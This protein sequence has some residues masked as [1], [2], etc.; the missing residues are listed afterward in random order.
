MTSLL[1]TETPA[2]EK[3]EEIESSEKYIYHFDNPLLKES[4]YI[5]IFGNRIE[6]LFPE[7]T[8]KSQFC[9]PIK[10][11]YINKQLVFHTNWLPI[12]TS[13]DFLK[14]QDI[15][16]R[17]YC[18]YTTVIHWNVWPST[19]ASPKY[20]NESSTL[21]NN[22]LYSLSCF[23]NCTT[24]SIEL[25]LKSS[26]S[27]VI[28]EQNKPFHVQLYIGPHKMFCSEKDLVVLDADSVNFILSY[29]LYK[30]AIF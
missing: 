5:Q 25:D 2:E 18:E 26:V 20:Y 17:L 6:I 1:D 3:K 16:N 10:Q 19:H 21:Y 23:E 29:V 27:P 14:C 4:G 22:S 13:T 15:L 9:V 28:A 30:L 12:T 7:Q 11:F 8:E 24:T